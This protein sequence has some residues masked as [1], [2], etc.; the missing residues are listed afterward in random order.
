MCLG[1]L[2]NGEVRLLFSS[3]QVEYARYW[4]K[5]MGLTEK[6]L[7]LPSSDCLIR[8]SALKTIAPVIYKDGSS[9]RAATKVKM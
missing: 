8:R 1:T 3:A 4:T 9:L 6:L 5:E 2:P 7:P